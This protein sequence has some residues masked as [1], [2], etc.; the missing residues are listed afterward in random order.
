MKRTRTIKAK[1]GELVIG[2]GRCA[3][4]PRGSSPQIVYAWGGEGATKND[5]HLLMG[6]FEMNSPALANELRKRG[7]DITTLKFSI[8]KK[9]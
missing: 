1:P 4:E 2:Y 7:Y 3:E 6:A 5:I 8:Q 9:L